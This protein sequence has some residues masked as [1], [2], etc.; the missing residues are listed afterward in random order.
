VSD[1]LVAA[2][3]AAAAWCTQINA[4]AHSEI[5][6]VPTERLAVERELLGPLPSLRPSIGRAMNRKVDRLA[7]A[8]FGSARYSV[9]IRL[10]GAQVRGVRVVE[11]V[12]LPVAQAI[13]NPGRASSPWH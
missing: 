8:R 3:V 11:A 2:N 4:A 5:C 1:V 9:P 12:D 6:A 10:I 13:R 7:C